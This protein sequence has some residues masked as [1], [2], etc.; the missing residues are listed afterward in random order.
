MDKHASHSE[1]SFQ[2][3][4]TTHRL[5]PNEGF[6]LPVHEEH[7]LVVR[8]GVVYVSLRSGDKAL[9]PGDEIVVHSGDFLGAWSEAHDDAELVVLRGG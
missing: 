1:K 4:V 2:V 3:E 7:T 6:V 9:I 8:R 5:A